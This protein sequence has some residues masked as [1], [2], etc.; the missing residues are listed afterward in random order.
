MN[1][2][3]RVP[4]KAV[5]AGTAAGLRHLERVYVSK[6][7]AAVANGDTDLAHELA[8]DLSSL[9]SAATDADQSACHRLVAKSGR[10]LAYRLF[11]R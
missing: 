5:A 3:N 2:T 6:V 7:N 10:P 8:D 1:P 4:S 11:G 9:T